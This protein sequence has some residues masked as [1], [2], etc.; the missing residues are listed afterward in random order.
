[1]FPDGATTAMR[2]RITDLWVRSRKQ[3]Q[4]ARVKPAAPAKTSGREEWRLEHS[5]SCSIKLQV[6]AFP[7]WLRGIRTLTSIQ[8]D[9]G[10]IPGLAQWGKE[11]VLQQVWL[12]FIVAVPLIQPLAWECPYAA[13]VAIKNK[14]K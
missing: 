9:V 5:W 1:M 8:E 7:S 2:L 10:S 14:N 13:G 4:A 3:L 12:R 11:L 6:A